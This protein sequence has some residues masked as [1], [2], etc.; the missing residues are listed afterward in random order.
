MPS[1]VVEAARM[2][3][4]GEQI[5]EADI[6]TQTAKAAIPIMSRPS[7]PRSTGRSWSRS[8]CRCAV[9]DRGIWRIA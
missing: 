2:A 4:Q 3:G 8:G 1:G 5:D 9:L 7:W 6:I